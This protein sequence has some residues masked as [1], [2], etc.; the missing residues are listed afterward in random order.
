[1]AVQLL[2][3]LGAFALALAGVGVY[4]VVSF[5]VAQRT[6]E[7]GVR[8]ALGAGRSVVRSWVVRQALAPVL[9]GG[10]LGLLGAVGVGRGLGGL[11]FEISGFDPVTLIAAVGLLI[12]IAVAAS[13]PPAMR[14]SGVDPA[15]TLR[16]S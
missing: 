9:V 4:A 7:I 3:V 8:M 13:L 16:D 6:R 5:A 12:A 11:L 2:L 1:M 14:A 10:L 15:V